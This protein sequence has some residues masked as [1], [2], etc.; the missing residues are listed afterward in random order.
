M[1]KRILIPHNLLSE[2]KKDGFGDSPSLTLAA[3]IVACN[4]NID[5]QSLSN[6]AFFES[7]SLRGQMRMV[8]LASML[9]D[10]DDH[11]ATENIIRRFKTE[12]IQSTAWELSCAANL[13]NCGFTIFPGKSNV[14]K[15]SAF[16]FRAVRGSFDVACE[17]YSRNTLNTD[18]YHFRNRLA[19]KVT[20]LPNDRPGYL[21]CILS[22]DH[23]KMEISASDLIKET[24][25]SLLYKE[26]KPSQLIF[27]IRDSFFNG[28]Q[29]RPII[30]PN[31]YSEFEQPDLYSLMEEYQ[32][33][34]PIVTLPNG[35]YGRGEFFRILREL[36]IRSNL[37]VTD[38]VDSSSVALPEPGSGN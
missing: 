25:A 33:N 5:L 2:A 29:Y 16:D 17:V 14:A 20:Q 23:I 31:P 18:S 13:A 15:G 19:Q 4:L 9:V 36:L 11:P 27:I 10:I 24:A 32:N 34:N 7:G 38:S 21:F 22:D 26:R 37:Y 1:N 28:M 12:N 35:E 6:D 3:G 8:K 30:I